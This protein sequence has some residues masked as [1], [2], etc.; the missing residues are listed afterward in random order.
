MIH[1]PEKSW[2]V[3]SDSMDGYFFFFKDEKNQSISLYIPSEE[4]Q[5]PPS[6][7]YYRTKEEWDQVQRVI[8]Y[9]GYMEPLNSQIFRI[10]LSPSGKVEV[11]ANAEQLDSF[12]QDSG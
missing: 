8:D 11:L 7:C 9:T 3:L 5:E 12:R 6:I 1:I 4:R 10:N 2:E